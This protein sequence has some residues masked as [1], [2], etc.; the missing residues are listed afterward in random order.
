MNKG[1]S[2]S[3]E[4]ASI[5][6]MRLYHCMR[7]KQRCLFLGFPRT[8]CKMCAHIATVQ[9]AGKKESASTAAAVHHSLC[10]RLSL[11]AVL[12]CSADGNN[13][14][15]TVL[16]AC[17]DRFPGSTKKKYQGSRICPML[18]TQ[19]TQL[20]YS[21]VLHFMKQQKAVTLSCIGTAI[22]GSMYG[23]YN[24][25][26][27]HETRIPLAGAFRTSVKANPTLSLPR[28]LACDVLDRY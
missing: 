7:K 4:P 14:N 10:S 8:K 6:K 25:A 11:K 1:L 20:I 27:T 17:S 24:S 22:E 5:P 9:R 15:C 18:V 16:F 26:P 2:V 12:K 13:V 28:S 19:T 23:H 21:C 3:T